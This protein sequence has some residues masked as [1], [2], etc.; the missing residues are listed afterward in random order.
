MNEKLYYISDW[1]IKPGHYTFNRHRY[2]EAYI[3]LGPW[4]ILNFR[5]IQSE[6]KG[7][8]NLIIANTPVNDELAKLHMISELIDNNEVYVGIEGTVWDWMDWPAAEQELY[9]D[10]L[11]RAAGVLYSNEQ[12]IKMMRLFAKNFLQ[13]PPCTNQYLEQARSMPGEYVFITNPSKRYQRG[14]ISHKLVYDSLPSTTP[15]YSM[16]YKRPASFNELLAFP[17]SYKLP[18]FQLLDYMNPDDFLSVVYNSKFGIDIHRDYS[19][20]TIAVNF[21]SVG[22]PLIGNIELDTQREIFPDTSFEWNDY[23]GIKRCI[24]NL[25]NDI[26][27]NLEVGR[28]ALENVKQKY[29]SN[30][31]VKKFMTDLDILRKSTKIK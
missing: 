19:A 25:H 5:D 21:G 4:H 15:V 13:A 9:I 8:G 20:G 3:E 18:G 22:V 24:Q 6:I 31:V 29:S 23:D 11:D 26:D 16:S 27:F 2:P 12:D 17:D 30:I 14:M 28:K 10:I 7:S 1:D